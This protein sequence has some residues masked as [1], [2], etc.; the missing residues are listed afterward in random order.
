MKNDFSFVIL[1]LEYHYAKLK[2]TVR[3]IKNKFPKSN[4][5]CIVPE[6]IDERDLKEIKDNCD[7]HVGSKTVTSLINKGLSVGEEDWK[8]FLMEGISV[9]YGLIKKYLYFLGFH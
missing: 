9:P 3:N 4:L 8:I 1:S 5:Y 6:M 2:Y 7:V